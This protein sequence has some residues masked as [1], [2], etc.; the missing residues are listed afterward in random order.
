VEARGPAGAPRPQWLI[1]GTLEGKDFFAFLREE[2]SRRRRF[3]GM[4]TPSA[5]PANV[6]FT[7]RFDQAFGVSYEP[8]VSPSAPYDAVYAVAYA[9][10]AAGAGPLDGA[11]LSRGID[12][13]VPPGRPID[14]GPAQIF[15]AVN[16]LRAGERIDLNGAASPL[17]FD[18]A[19]GESPADEVVL[20]V[21]ADG[22]GAPSGAVESGVR[23]DAKARTLSGEL[24]CR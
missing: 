5:T 21:G 17:D 8:A 14:V 6:K 12:R 16:A 4:T 24:R 2:P 1:P 15:D 3:L 10:F 18:R 7:T 9:A 23:F 20:C 22:R 13:L 19:T 11:A